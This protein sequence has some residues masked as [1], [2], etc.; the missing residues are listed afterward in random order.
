M[1]VLPRVFT[2]LPLLAIFAGCSSPSSESTALPLSAASTEQ[3]ITSPAWPAELQPIAD[4][5]V[6]VATAKSEF[7]SVPQDRYPIGIVAVDPASGAESV[8]T[9]DPLFSLPT[10]IA[11]SPDGQLYIA[12]LTATGK[13]AIIHFDPRTHIARVI[14]SGEYLEGPNGIMWRNGFLY[15]VND[16]DSVSGVHRIV[17]VD[18]RTGEQ[19]LVTGGPGFE[20]GVGIAPAPGNVAFVADEPGNVQGG[21][22]PNKDETNRIW[23]V[24]LAT[25]QQ[26]NG[27]AIASGVYDKIS[28][29][30]LRGTHKLV[31]AIGTGDVGR[32]E[33]GQPILNPDGTPK[34]RYAGALTE[35]DVGDGP[36]HGQVKLLAEL[37]D[38]AGLDG[39]TVGRDGTVF[40][41]AISTGPT[42]GR[43]YRYDDKDGLKL[44]APRQGAQ[45]NLSLVEG[46]HVHALC[47]LEGGSCASEAECCEGA[48]CNAGKCGAPPFIASG[49]LLVATA[50]SPSS[51][52]DES[53]FPTGI[54]G[55]NPRTGAQSIVSEGGLFSLP[56]YLCEAPDRQIYVS[57][58]TANGKGAVIRVDPRSGAQHLVASGELIDGPIAIAC[59]DDALLVANIGDGSGNVHALVRVDPATGAQKLV[60]SGGFSHANGIAI[61]TGR[62]AFVGADTVWSIDLD[63]GAQTLFASGLVGVVDMVREA[64]FNLLFARQGVGIVRIDGTTKTQTTLAAFPA[65][66]GLDSVATGPDGTIYAGAISQGMTPGAVYAI[67]PTNGATKVLTQGKNLSLVEGMTVFR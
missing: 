2:L 48:A 28:D 33:K 61:G 42:P 60:S 53:K 22:D 43:V 65:S 37:G 20:V 30:A 25:G 35:I 21:L 7:A 9:S 17:R 13:G 56:T 39:I 51:S 47:A 58:L 36:E 40:I 49:T 29:M 27:P 52:N 24:D 15:V 34:Y 64:P 66:V 6:L 44:L 57:D 12:D 38:D 41:G 8:M 16:G 5:V 54:V 18:P 10:Y 46:M 26:T 59:E 3:P 31:C 23:T 55:V 11:E 19:H 67:H 32:D 62:Q 50:P 4:G 14:A 63:T 1:K 45:T